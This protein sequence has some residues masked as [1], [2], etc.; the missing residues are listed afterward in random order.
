MRANRCRWLLSDDKAD[1]GKSWSL[2]LSDDKTLARGLMRVRDSVWDSTLGRP[3][4]NSIDCVG[5]DS[6]NIEILKWLLRQGCP[7]KSST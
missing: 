5:L 2:A 7:W 4:D 3:G 1:A 6:G